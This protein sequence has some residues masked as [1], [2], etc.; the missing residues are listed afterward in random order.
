[1]PI[2]IPLVERWYWKDIPVVEKGCPRERWY[3][4]YTRILSVFRADLSFDL[5]KEIE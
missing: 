2:L 1:M 5:C 3:M 4:T